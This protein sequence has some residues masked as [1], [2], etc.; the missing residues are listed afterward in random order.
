MTALPQSEP[1]ALAVGPLE[2]I[3]V[4]HLA[5]VNGSALMLSVVELRMLTELVRR[6]DRIV[7]REE[8]STRVWGRELRPGDRSVDVYVHKLRV[9]LEAALPGWSFIHTHFGL[10]YRLCPQPRKAA[11]RLVPERSRAGS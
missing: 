4:E 2:V 6:A 11:P 7:S 1:E 10:G 9:K 5:R 3:P 8:L